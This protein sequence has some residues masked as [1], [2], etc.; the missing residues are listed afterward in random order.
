MDSKILAQPNPN[1]QLL[2]QK[3]YAVNHPGNWLF[4]FTTTRSAH[5]TYSKY[6]SQHD[7]EPWLERHNSTWNKNRVAS[8]CT[9][10]KPCNVELT[11]GDGTDFLTCVNLT[12]IKFLCVYRQTVR[13][14]ESQ[15]E[16]LY[17]CVFVKSSNILYV[18]TVRV[19][20]FLIWL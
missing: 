20:I 2:T 11:G 10:K 15:P 9:F 13:R 1:G 16:E 5:I 18:L 4:L 3:A 7:R 8:N 6:E 12:C 17:A 14:V 19:C